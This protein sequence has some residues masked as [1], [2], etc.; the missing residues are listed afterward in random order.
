MI[1]GQEVSSHTYICIHDPG[2]AT[3]SYCSPLLPLVVS[4][5]GVDPEYVLVSN[6]ADAP[7]VCKSRAVIT[8]SSVIHAA[9]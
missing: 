5:S 3:E 2:Y 1:P 9:G 8:A 7:M 4:G 6:P